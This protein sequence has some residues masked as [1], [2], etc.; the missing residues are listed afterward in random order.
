[1][2]RTECGEEQEKER[3]ASLGA[4]TVKTLPAVQETPGSLS[5]LGAELELRR[6]GNLAVFLLV[7]TTPQP[8]KS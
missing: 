2:R 8:H 5:R 6:S 7:K 3:G 1:M 4:Q